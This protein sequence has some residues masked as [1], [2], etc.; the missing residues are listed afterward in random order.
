MSGCPLRCEHTEHQHYFTDI[1]SFSESLA[2]QKRI[3]LLPQ[4]L[5]KN[6]VLETYPRSVQ[7][8]KRKLMKLISLHKALQNNCIKQDAQHLRIF[9]SKKLATLW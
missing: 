9:L 8:T 3:P 1:K 6:T 2:I 7:R 5:F 4:Q